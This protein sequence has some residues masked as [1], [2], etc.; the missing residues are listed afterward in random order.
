MSA[1]DSAPQM[2]L[3]VQLPGCFDG[4]PVR[5]GS[6]F[7]SIMKR[8]VLASILAA[9]LLAE[10]AVAQIPP[11]DQR[12]IQPRSINLTVQQG[13]IIKENVKDMRIDQVPPSN[14]IKI[15]N[16]VPPNIG[17]HAFPPLVVEKVPKVKT[18]KFFIT[19]NQIVVVGP[20]NVIADII[21]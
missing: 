12:M 9:T 17:L 5:L 6:Q 3:R 21:K 4:A 16:K 14:E 15:G 19:E 2:E 18:H 20:Q 7:R 8:A 1:F 11:T 13:F 10:G